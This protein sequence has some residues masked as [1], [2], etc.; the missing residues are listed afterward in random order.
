MAAS[1]A[2]GLASGMGG[3][4]PATYAADTAPP[5]MNAAAMSLFRML[6]DIGYV[7]GPIGLG[8]VTD[9]YGPAT[10]LAVSAGLLVASG[11][12]FGLFAPETWK[13]RK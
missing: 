13:G 2:W 10:G 1:L 3:P 4:A 9:F 8:L 11:I 7:A 12:A 5:G 6:G